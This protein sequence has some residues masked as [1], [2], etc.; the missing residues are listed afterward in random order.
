MFFS[1]DKKRDRHDFD[2]YKS[3]GEGN[4]WEKSLEVKDLNSEQDDLYL[5]F[6]SPSN[7]YFSSNRNDNNVE[8]C[9]N[10]IYSFELI[11]A[12]SSIDSFSQTIDLDSPISLYF[13]NDEPKEDLVG[14]MTNAEY[15]SF[16]VSYFLKQEEYLSI[17]PSKE[18]NLFFE[19]RLKGN[20]ERLNSLLQ[21]ILIELKNNEKKRKKEF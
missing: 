1:S 9:C 18:I 10:N 20:Y 17:N 21:D 14:N 2:I 3:K 15:K 4:L 19:R 8:D 6:Y 5:N 11:S 16:Y 7:G 13:H 12:D